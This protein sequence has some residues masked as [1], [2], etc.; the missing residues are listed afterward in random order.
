MSFLKGLAVV[1]LILIAIAHFFPN[2]YDSSREWLS[3]KLGGATND[4]V[5]SGFDTITDITGITDKDVTD[6]KCVD[7]DDCE[8]HFEI[9]GLICGEDRKCEVKKPDRTLNETA[10]VDEDGE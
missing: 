6:F 10:E 3:D 8:R 9:D 1:A 5:A 4:K 2:P 7:A